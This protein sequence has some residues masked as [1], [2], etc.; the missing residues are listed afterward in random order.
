MYYECKEFGI[1]VISDKRHEAVLKCSCSVGVFTSRYVPLEGQC[2]IDVQRSVFGMCVMS[3]A[4]AY[5]SVEHE[6]SIPYARISF[7]GWLLIRIVLMMAN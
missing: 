2:F 5:C 1:L 6:I 4:I 3:G 7:A